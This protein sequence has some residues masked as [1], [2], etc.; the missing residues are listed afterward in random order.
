MKPV[1]EEADENEL[2]LFNYLEGNLSQEETK[3]LESRLL[4][5][6][7]LQTELSYWRESF[8]EADSYDTTS[9]ELTLL[10]PEAL[11]IRRLGSLQAIIAALLASLLSLVA[12][13]LAVKSPYMFHT[14]TVSSLLPEKTQQPVTSPG[15]NE[16]TPVKQ[17]IKQMPLIQ[18]IPARTNLTYAT[19]QQ[20]VVTPLPVLK[21][22]ALPKNEINEL[23]LLAQK[24]I[25]MQ[26]KKKPAARTLSG[27][28]RR[29]IARMKE[30]ALQQRKASEFS[31]GQVPYVVPL[32]TNNF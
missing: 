14:Y 28:E 2:L 5:D 18:A 25:K 9:L 23:A 10:K 21:L 4:T 8:V 22:R 20:I 24:E 13:P 19:P 16:N 7:S 31:K 32:N 12:V 29:Q 27:K 1:F 30:R 3:E 15:L 6:V 17:H 26:W 11:P